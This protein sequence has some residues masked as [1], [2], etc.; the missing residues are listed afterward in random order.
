MIIKEKSFFIYDLLADEYHELIPFIELLINYN[1]E[2]EFNSDNIIKNILK[3]C[4]LLEIDNEG[5]LK[6]IKEKIDI[7]LSIDKRIEVYPIV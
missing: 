3:I 7:I 5:I 2:Y 4:S 6:S 1:L